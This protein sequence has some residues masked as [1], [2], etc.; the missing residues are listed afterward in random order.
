[1]SNNQTHT[2]PPAKQPKVKC[3]GKSTGMT[4]EATIAQKTQTPTVNI[5]L[6]PR[7]PGKKEINWSE[8]IA[9]QLSAEELVLCSGVLLGYLPG[10]K[11]SRE[12]K[13]IEIER[14][15][16][17]I[18]IKAT[19]GHG[20]LYSLPVP[21]GLVFQV[22][23]LILHQLMKKVTVNSQ[24]LSLHQLKGHVRYTGL[25]VIRVA[26]IMSNNHRR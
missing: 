6:A 3:F 22:S 9:V 4:L 1:M 24:S 12:D 19:Q 10:T 18:Y 8:K 25:S 14:Q 20:R 21:M 16:K 13:G 11:F 23:D 15:N 2:V 17:S 5:E 7:F 26:E